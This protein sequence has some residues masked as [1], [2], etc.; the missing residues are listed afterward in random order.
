ML[1]P[2]AAYAYLIPLI[3]GVWW[4]LGIVI[5]GIAVLATFLWLNIL[6]IRQ[7]MRR[8]NAPDTTDDNADSD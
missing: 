7:W 2:V 1:M 5:A 3:G 8:K 6:K 4:L